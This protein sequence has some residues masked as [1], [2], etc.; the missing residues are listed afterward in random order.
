[1]TVTPDQFRA[2]LGR[3]ATGV[4]VVTMR[5]PDGD[6]HAFQEGIG[7]LVQGLGIP[8]LPMGLRGLW[9]WKT[10]RLL[11]HRQIAVHL[12][13]P[14]HFDSETDARQIAQQLEARVKQLADSR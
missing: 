9:H 2:A 6:V 4:T 1:M 11:A 3:F 8:V 12:G 10:R 14:M 5:T 7:V 13:E